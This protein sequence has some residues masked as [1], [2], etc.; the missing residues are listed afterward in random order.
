[1]ESP[2]VHT[3][4]FP[5]D[6]VVNYINNCRLLETLFVYALAIESL[7]LLCPTLPFNRRSDYFMTIV[8]YSK[9]AQQF[10]GDEFVRGQ[11]PSQTWFF[12]SCPTC[13]KPSPSWS[14]DWTDIRRWAREPCPTTTSPHCSCSQPAT[15]Q[16]CFTNYRLPTDSQMWWLVWDTT[17]Y[18][19]NKR[20]T[21]VVSHSI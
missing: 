15:Q 18:G 21:A 9:L 13:C 14:R 1:M 12:S 4:F 5:M 10:F 7:V 6:L 2:T 8:N 17:H 19:S 3:I 20:W 16:L 11:L